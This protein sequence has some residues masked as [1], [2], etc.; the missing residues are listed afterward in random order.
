M[1]EI[2]LR[3]GYMKPIFKLILLNGKIQENY[4]YLIGF[5][6]WILLNFTKNTHIDVSYIHMPKLFI[7]RS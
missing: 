1:E 7:E 5:G 2:V 3:N 6:H 4:W